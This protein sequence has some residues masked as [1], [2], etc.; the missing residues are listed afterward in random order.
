MFFKKIKIQIINVLRVFFLMMIFFFLFVNNNLI[1][2]RSVVCCFANDVINVHPEGKYQKTI[3]DIINE[4]KSY[5]K[6]VSHYWP[7]GHHYHRTSFW[8]LDDQT[9]KETTTIQPILS[10]MALW[11]IINIIILDIFFVTKEKSNRP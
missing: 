10:F 3:T 4:S 8:W 2:T 7:L 5:Q 9:K 6:K 1:E 11:F